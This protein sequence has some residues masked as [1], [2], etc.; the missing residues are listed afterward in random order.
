MIS[1]SFDE[2]DEQ[3]I[4][5]LKQMTLFLTDKYYTNSII[6]GKE[7]SDDEEEKLEK[8]NNKVEDNDLIS[9]DKSLN[10]SENNEKLIIKYRL[11]EFLDDLILLNTNEDLSEDI[12]NI[13][14]YLGN[15]NNLKTLNKSNKVK[16]MTIHSSK[17]L[18]FNTVF[19]VGV[20]KGYYPIYHPSVKDKKKHEEEERRMF[21]VAITRAKQNCFISYAQKRLMGT[22]KVMNREKSQFINELENKCLDF[23]GDIINDDNNNENNNNFSFK[24]SL[25][26]QNLFN[27][28]NKNFNSN[29]K[30]K[31]YTKYKDKNFFKNKNRFINKKRYNAN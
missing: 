11:K 10:K 17:G 4:N 29:Y 1:F 13:N 2:E 8:T 19:I 27:D 31:N 18:E 14:S 6:N 21:Y 16:L 3:L 28:F 9:E 15:S 20:E 7:N 5:L 30:N 24:K 23:T 22:G 12:S 25:F 26:S